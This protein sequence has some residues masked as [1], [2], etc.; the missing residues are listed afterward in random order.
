M[1]NKYYS[2]TVSV[3]A[4]ED[5]KKIC[6]E[7]FNELFN[8]CDGSIKELAFNTNICQEPNDFLD[9]LKKSFENKT[10]LELE[11]ISIDDEEIDT[12]DSCS[13]GDYY[14]KVNNVFIKSKDAEEVENKFNIELQE[15]S[16]AEFG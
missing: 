12:N 10:N 6:P 7:E 9:N 14:W 11:L 2:N 5:L 16:Y 4:E 13:E 3:I 15:F 1:G 8:S